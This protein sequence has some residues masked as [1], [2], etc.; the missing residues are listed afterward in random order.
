M[1]CN[2]YVYVTCHDDVGIVASSLQV[3]N[4]LVHVFV[5][6]RVGACNFM[7][8]LHG[9]LLLLGLSEEMA[10]VVENKFIC[11]IYFCWC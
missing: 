1:H 4:F 6:V 8:G 11:I 5:Y 2:T 7:C 3:R 10:F 9:L